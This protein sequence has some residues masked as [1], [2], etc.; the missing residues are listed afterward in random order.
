MIRTIGNKVYSGVKYQL[1]RFEIEFNERI[2]NADFNANDQKINDMKMSIL[3]F[4]LHR[5]LA[6]KY[7]CREITEDTKVIE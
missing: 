7:R 4:Q 2:G 6:K 5:E 3:K 1:D